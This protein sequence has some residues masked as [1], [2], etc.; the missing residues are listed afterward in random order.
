MS[1]YS[2][3]QTAVFE[4]MHVRRRSA[5]QMNF[6]LKEAVS[7]VHDSEGGND[8]RPVIFL[9]KEI[10]K[11]KDGSLTGF[12]RWILFTFG[13][14]IDETGKLVEASCRINWNPKKVSFNWKK[15]AEKALPADFRRAFSQKWTAFSIRAD[16]QKV[17]DGFDFDAELRKLLARAEKK[18]ASPK[19]K[20]K[21]TTG[22]VAGLSAFITSR[23]ATAQVQ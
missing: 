17:Y 14:R 13:A 22:D 20:D 8:L 18:I 7:L 16:Q 12:V 9:V 3:F 6:L 2:E 11:I 10:A 1:R 5:D 21:V 15:D 23:T 4:I 19:E